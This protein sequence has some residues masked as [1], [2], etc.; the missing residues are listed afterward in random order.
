MKKKVYISL[1]ADNIHHG[2]INLINEGKKYGD[3]IIGL[4]TDKAVATHKKLPILNYEQRKLIIQNIS[5]VTDVIPQT[6]WDDSLTIQKL[7]PEFVIHGDDW[8]TGKQAVLRK[9]V[10][11]TLDKY[12]GKLIEVPYTKGISSEAISSKSKKVGI[13]PDQRIKTLKRSKRY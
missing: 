11:E 7:K 4:L 2:H 10:I 13:S 6:E 12:G 8:I 1:T 9:N 5:G 3:V